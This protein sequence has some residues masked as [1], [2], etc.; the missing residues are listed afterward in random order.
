MTKKCDLAGSVFVIRALSF[1]RHSSL[2]LRHFKY[3]QLASSLAN[4]DHAAGEHRSHYAVHPPME[5]PKQ[6]DLNR[7]GACKFYL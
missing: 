6:F 1:L 3:D 4:P 2:E 7:G 5:N